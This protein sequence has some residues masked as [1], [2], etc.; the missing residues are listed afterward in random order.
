MEESSGGFT[1]DSPAQE[2][3]QSYRRELAAMRDVRRETV[4][5]SRAPSSVA[6]DAAQGD[7]VLRYVHRDATGAANSVLAGQWECAQRELAKIVAT[8]SSCRRKARRQ[9]TVPTWAVNWVRAFCF[10]LT[11]IAQVARDQRRRPGISTKLV[12]SMAASSAVAA[13][14]ATHSS[15]RSFVAIRFAGLTHS[16]LQELVE[17]TP[18]V[19]L[20]TRPLAEP[21]TDR[22]DLSATIVRALVV[23]QRQVAPAQARPQLL[24]RDLEERQR[25]R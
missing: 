5:R 2:R 14:N 20:A 15:R 24:E 25:H 1:Q 7:S 21:G 13:I 4:S 19:Q 22:K 12:P 8:G 11:D 6:R 18:S 10:A 23:G 3:R 9:L 17:G 16:L